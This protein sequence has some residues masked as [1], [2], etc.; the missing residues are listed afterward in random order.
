MKEELNK[1]YHQRIQKFAIELK[2]IKT[3]INWMALI[4]VMEF[5]LGVVVAVVLI[6]DGYYGWGSLSIVGFGILFLYLVKIHSELKVQKAHWEHLVQINEE[7]IQGLEGDFSQFENGEEF[8]EDEHPYI[9]DLDILGDHSIFQFINRTCSTAG[10]TLLASWLKHP[11]KE[12]SEIIARQGAVKEL[13]SLLDWRQNFQAYKHLTQEGSTEPQEMLTWLKQP[14]SILHKKAYKII[15]ILFP[16][17][18]S[19]TL[20]IVSLGIIPFSFV[21][22][23]ILI[24]LMIVGTQAQ[25]FVRDASQMGK[26]AKFIRKYSQLLKEIETQEFTSPK[27]QALG[28]HLKHENKTAS[29]YLAELASIIGSIEQGVSFI[30]LIFNG[31]VMWNLQYL[32]RLEKWEENLNADLDNWFQVVAEVDALASLA[33]LYY[34]KPEYTFPEVEENFSL[35]AQALGHP[36]LKEDSRVDNFVDFRGFGELRIITGAN[37]AGKSTYLRTVGVNLILAATGAPVCAREFK[38]QPIDV[39]TS[40]RTK[41]SLQ[42]NESFFYAELKRLKQVI[43]ELNQGKPTFIILDEILKGTNST[44]QHIGSKA[45]IEQLVKLQG[46]GLIATHDL[47]LGELVETY[48]NNI[49]NQCFEIEIV[50]DELSFDYK[51]RQGINQNLNATFLMKKMGITV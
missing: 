14:A 24:Q 9:Y 15:L 50:Q 10:K 44:D 48:P 12:K 11:A 41:D 47:S 38:F 3:K 19:T 7:E 49:Q 40:M 26:R 33:N 20:V 22:I 17:L 51:L 4:R 5:L 23:P 1:I 31:L 8:I 42:E 18:T 16:I 39:Y 32:Y 21:W 36:L 29:Q 34:N 46:V 37:M 13:K 28:Q 6:E 43:D 25:K 30:G 27:L 2:K 45:L 35:K